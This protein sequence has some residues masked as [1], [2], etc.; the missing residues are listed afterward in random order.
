MLALPCPKSSPRPKKNTFLVYSLIWT[1]SFTSREQSTQWDWMCLG[2]WFYFKYHK[3]DSFWWSALSECCYTLFPAKEEASAR[4]YVSS[5]KFWGSVPGLSVNKPTHFPRTSHAFS[6]KNIQ[7][8]A[9]SKG[10]SQ[11][12]TYD[13]VSANTASWFPK[14]SEFQSGHRVVKIILNT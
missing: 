9:A 6:L 7:L 11:E 13:K 14:A 8:Q 10:V 2:L 1:S 3:H 12:A 5:S 4:F